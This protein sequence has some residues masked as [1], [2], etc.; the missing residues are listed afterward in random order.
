MESK[1]IMPHA[2]LQGTQRKQNDC[3]KVSLLVKLLASAGGGGADRR[4][5]TSVFV[6]LTFHLRKSA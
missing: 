1:K 4:L 2:E 5:P 3:A 6:L